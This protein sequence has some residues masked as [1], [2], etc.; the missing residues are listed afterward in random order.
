MLKEGGG[1]TNDRNCAYRFFENSEK[2]AE[3][4]GLDKALIQ[5]FSTILTDLLCGHVIDR[6]NFRKY[7][8]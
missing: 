8:K 6:E 5:R 7:T 4:T 3:I 1:T 2:V